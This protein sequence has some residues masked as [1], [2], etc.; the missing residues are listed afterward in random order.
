MPPQRGEV[1]IK[2]LADR[3]LGDAAQELLVDL[4]CILVCTNYTPEALFNNRFA[5][6][7]FFQEALE[8]GNSLLK[9]LPS[10]RRR[11]GRID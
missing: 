11:T 9:Y 10:Q 7:A 4:L 1:Q 5:H 6:F 8:K 3:P 2:R